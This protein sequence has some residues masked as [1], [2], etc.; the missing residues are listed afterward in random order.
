MLYRVLLLIPPGFD[1]KTLLG[2]TLRADWK[3]AKIP[4]E[5]SELKALFSENPVDHCMLFQPAS[6]N[7]TRLSSPREYYTQSL[8]QVYQAHR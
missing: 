5:M 4:T 7:S 6:D 2:D 1:V 8:L 3:A